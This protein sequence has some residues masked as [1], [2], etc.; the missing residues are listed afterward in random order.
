MYTFKYWKGIWQ[1]NNT[2]VFPII[3]GEGYFLEWKHLAE[4]LMV[5]LLSSTM[6]TKDSVRN[7]KNISS[8]TNIRNVIKEMLISHSTFYLKRLIK[9][10]ELH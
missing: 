4:N 8:I 5:N 10:N 1:K 2:D 6:D 7:I 9:K 3:W